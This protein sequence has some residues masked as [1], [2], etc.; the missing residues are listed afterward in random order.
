MFH[1]QGCQRLTHPGEPSSRKV[2]ATK[3]VLYP[4]RLGVYPSKKDKKFSTR[5]DHGGTGSQIVREILVCERCAQG[6]DT[7]TLPNVN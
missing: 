2:V 4:P 1:C 6:V 3:R 7:P 5:D